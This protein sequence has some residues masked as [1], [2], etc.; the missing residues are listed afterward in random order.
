MSPKPTKE[1]VLKL[2]KENFTN[3]FLNV[4]ID[5]VDLSHSNVVII[6]NILIKPPLT[7]E[8]YPYNKSSSTS[9]SAA[10]GKTNSANLIIGYVKCTNCKK[11][12]ILKRVTKDQSK[13]GKFFYNCMDCDF[14]KWADETKRKF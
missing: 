3:D 8:D 13:N 12:A 9:K 2:K 10:G 1:T 5:I 6:S 11:P 4:F 7:K 14:F